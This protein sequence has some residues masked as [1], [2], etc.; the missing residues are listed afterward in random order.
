[1]IKTRKMSYPPVTIGTSFMLVIFIILCMVVFAALSLSNA[2]RDQHLSEKNAAHTIAYYTA[3]NKGEHMLAKIDTALDGC[4]DFE[5]AIASL[6]TLDDLTLQFSKETNALTACTIIPMNDIENLQ[7][8]LSIHPQDDV[9]YKI[10]TW[11]QISS[12]EWEGQQNLS[13]FGND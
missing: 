7:I 12:S 13:V 2:V 6:E 4:T 10:I 8:V 9:K 11:K 3:N 5:D 1:M